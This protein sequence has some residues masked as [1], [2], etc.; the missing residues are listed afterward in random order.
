MVKKKKALKK[1]KLSSIN[2]IIYLIMLILII[3]LGLSIIITVSIQRPIY[4]S[5]YNT[6]AVKKNDHLIYIQI[7]NILLALILFCKWYSL[8]TTKY[9]I[10]KDPN[11]RFKIKNN[12]RKIILNLVI[13]FLGVILTIISVLNR[14]EISEE[15]ITEYGIIQSRETQKL[16][17]IKQV[18]YGMSVESRSRRWNITIDLELFNGEHFKF[19]QYEFRD[20]D[21]IDRLDKQISKNNVQK[22]INPN[23]NINNLKI[24]RDYNENEWEVLFRLFQ[25]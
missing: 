21:A 25:N 24:N 10:K 20:I 4:F 2:K 7:I 17:N 3:L 13:I 19:Y 18:T 14:T 16:K 9:D 22:K 5:N 11:K 1:T 6:L 15:A 12:K 8:W 23:V